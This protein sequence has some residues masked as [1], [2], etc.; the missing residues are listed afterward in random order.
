MIVNN[1]RDWVGK[2]VSTWEGSVSSAFCCLFTGNTNKKAILLF[3]TDIFIVKLNKVGNFF[4][5]FIEPEAFIFRLIVN[6]IFSFACATWNVNIVCLDYRAVGKQIFFQPS[7]A[8]RH[9]E[10]I[11]E[12]NKKYGKSINRKWKA[13]SFFRLALFIFGFTTNVAIVH[14]LVSQIVF[15][16]NNFC[17]HVLN[18]LLPGRQNEKIS[19]PL[20]SLSHKQRRSSTKGLNSLSSGRILQHRTQFCL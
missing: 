1:R 3:V 8:A 7:Q 10:W 4:V 9:C 17:I 13:A 6:D 16:L 20:N 14:K 2:N 18:S 5:L 12:M 11:F 15:M 19:V